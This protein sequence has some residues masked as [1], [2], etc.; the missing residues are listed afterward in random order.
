MRALALLFALAL[1][2]ACRTVSKNACRDDG[3]C[4]AGQSCQ[5]HRCAPTPEP[6]APPPR[7]VEMRRQVERS[8][9]Q[10]DEK[11]LRKLRQAAGE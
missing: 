8:L 6:I 4:P 2:P 1:L 3:D 5:G 11:T 9:E 10:A 7:A